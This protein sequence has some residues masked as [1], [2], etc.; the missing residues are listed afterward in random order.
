MKNFDYNKL[1]NL[2]IHE[3]RDFARTVGVKSPTSLKKEEIIE[4]VLLIL[5]GESEPYVNVTKQGRPAKTQKQFDE[6]VEFFIPKNDYSKY[7]F[8]DYDLNID[9]DLEFVANAGKA[10]YNSKSDSEIVKG[11]LD[12]N[13]NGYGIIRVHSMPSD[14]D[15]F[16]HYYSIKT[17]NLQ[18]GDILEGEVK[19]IQ[20]GKPR[21]MYN[22][23]TVNGV[24]LC[25][26]QPKTKFNDLPYNSFTKKVNFNNN[27]AF[28]ELAKL[29]IFEGSRNLIF[30][31]NGFK[32]KDVESFVNNL[33]DEYVVFALNF[34]S[35]PEEKEF[36]KD[37]LIL[38][39]FNFS[40]EDGALANVSNLMFEQAKRRVE[41]EKKVVIVINK[42][43]A[44]LKALNNLQSGNYLSEL[45]SNAVN[46]IKKFVMC[47]KNVNEN[48]NLTLFVLESANIEE[49][50]LNFINY[51]LSNICNNVIK[52][53]NNNGKFTF[54]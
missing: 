49:K 31:N 42:L 6:L 36:E 29:D 26:L 33:S 23:L 10:E 8:G 17:N 52:L 20:E 7:N 43:S 32:L 30:A 4:Q 37:N 18:T 9:G 44:L 3:L 51:D 27:G 13:K 16:L 12:I 2:R 15:V 41:D 11:C 39:N 35:M 14:D 28:S 38:A 24:P 25:Q 54:N 45:K 19:L 1:N 21:V 22:I 53:N 5:S 40:V 34:N 47:A 46:Q 50:L 48:T